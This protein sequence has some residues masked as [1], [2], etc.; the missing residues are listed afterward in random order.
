MGSE[1]D[2]LSEDVRG[3]DAYDDRTTRTVALGVGCRARRIVV[4]VV[5]GVVVV[6]VVVYVCYF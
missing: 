4:G 6:G 2:E 5:V 1:C 3:S